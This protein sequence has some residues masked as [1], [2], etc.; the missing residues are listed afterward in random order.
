MIIQLFNGRI[1]D[2]CTIER[3]GVYIDETSRYFV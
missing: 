1:E 2:D 3:I